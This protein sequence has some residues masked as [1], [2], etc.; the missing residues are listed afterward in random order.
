MYVFVRLSAIYMHTKLF[1]RCPYGLRR[2]YVVFLVS[3]HISVIR[4]IIGVSALCCP[5]NFIF[6]SSPHFDIEIML[7]FILENNA[8]RAYLR[9]NRSNYE[10]RFLNNSRFDD[11][12]IDLFLRIIHVFKKCH[13]LISCIG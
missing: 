3:L 12:V 9:S 2:L 10:S 6:S 11:R 8:I 5:R 4:R 7:G 1:K 13:F